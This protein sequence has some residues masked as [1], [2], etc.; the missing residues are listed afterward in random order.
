MYIWLLSLAMLGAV[1]AAPVPKYRI[2][3][4]AAKHTDFRALHTYTWTSGWVAFDHV[5]D[6]HIVA[7][8]DTELA[9]LGLV[10]RAAEPCDVIVTYGTLRR[11]DVDVH[12]ERPHHSREFPEYPVSTLFVLMMEPGSRRELFRARVDV[13]V[14]TDTAHLGQQ[15]D[16]IVAQMFAEYPTRH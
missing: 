1:V 13:P 5:L 11:T 7:A 15:I 14:E 8:I 2:T 4:K 16:T 3:V 10:K 6:R 9:S 12:A